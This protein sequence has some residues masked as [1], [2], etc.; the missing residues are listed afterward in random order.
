MN[1][2]SLYLNG[3]EP[4][5]NPARRTSDVGSDGCVIQ[6]PIPTVVSVR[7]VVT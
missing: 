7:T 5:G 3:L 2:K 6:D 1:L 4:D